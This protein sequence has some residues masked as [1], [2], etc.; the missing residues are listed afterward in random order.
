[1]IRVIETVSKFDQLKSEWERLQVGEE[2]RVFQTFAWCRLAWEH[3][4]SV[5]RGNRLWIVRWWKD[6]GTDSVIFPF[7][8]DGRGMLRFIMD[9]HSDVCNAVYQRVGNRHYCYKEVAEA[10][11]AEPR[12]R[13]VWLQK[14]LGVSEVLH[15]LGVQLEHSLIYRDNAYSFIELPQSKDPIAEMH[16]MSSKDRAVLRSYVRKTEGYTYRCLSKAQ[17]DAFPYKMIEALRQDMLVH[18]KRTIGFFEDTLFRFIEAFYETGACEIALLEDNSSA[19]AL[20]FRLLKGERSI[21]WVFMYARP[22][23]VTLL[24]ARYICQKANVSRVQIDFGVG[25]YKYKLGNYR[26]QPEALFSLRNSKTTL[27][28]IQQMIGI[29]WR[30]TKDFLKVKLGRAH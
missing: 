20:S 1:M 15:G 16:Y 7:Y 6:G 5:D 14:M 22:K 29:N 4:L 8:I 3:M 18:T 10:I 27:G 25:V 17:G 11:L 24:Y 13:H 2:M 21:S 26:P 19:I 12:I 9:T 30:F 23:A 28:F